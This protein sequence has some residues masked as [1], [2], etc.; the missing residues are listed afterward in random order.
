[1]KSRRFARGLLNNACW[2]ADEY[3]WNTPQEP[4]GL[5][6]DPEQTQLENTRDSFYLLLELDDHYCFRSAIYAFS[7]CLFCRLWVTWN[8]CCYFRVLPSSVKQAENALWA[9]TPLYVHALPTLT[10]DGKKKHITISAPQNLVI[11][12]FLLLLFMLH[13]WALCHWETKWS[14]PKR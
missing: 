9:I 7:P 4:L 5:C 6:Q 3:A 11:H 12:W 8:S 10:V 14:K 1:M 13:R 2:K